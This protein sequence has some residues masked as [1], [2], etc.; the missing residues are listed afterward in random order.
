MKSSNEN[1]LEA[2]KKIAEAG[3]TFSKDDEGWI[4]NLYPS[5]FNVNWNG[6]ASVPY[7]EAVV[8]AVTECSLINFSPEE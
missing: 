1:V 7:E 6:D 4:L 8:Q 5:H 2:A 3:C